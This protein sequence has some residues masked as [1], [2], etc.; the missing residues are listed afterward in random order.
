MAPSRSLRWR[1]T[2]QLM[3]VDLTKACAAFDRQLS[4]AS[5]PNILRPLHGRAADGVATQ[6][7][8]WHA[9]W[10]H[11]RITTGFTLLEASDEATLV[12]ALAAA[13]EIA[14]R[15]RRIGL[16]LALVLPEDAASLRVLLARRGYAV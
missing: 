6:L 8:Q 9:E 10:G 11:T 7:S 16:A 15:C 12:E 3:G 14:A 2:R 13:P 1:S 4:P 5:L